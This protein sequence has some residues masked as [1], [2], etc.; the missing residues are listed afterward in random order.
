MKDP[1]KLSQKDQFIEIIMNGL[2]IVL[3]L[4]CAMKVLFF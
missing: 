1:I 3:I 2:A 4:A